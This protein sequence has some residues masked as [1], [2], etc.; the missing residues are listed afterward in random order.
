MQ[1]IEQI[2]IND[3]GSSNPGPGCTFIASDGTFINIYPKIDDHEDLCGYLADNYRVEFEYTDADWFV[4][5]LGWIRLR[6]DP[7]H[8]A[9]V[10]NG[11]R[12]NN[13]QFYSLQEWLEYCEERYQN[14][15]GNIQAYV[16]ICD[17][18][19]YT[20]HTYN[21]MK[22]EFAEDIVRACKRYYTSGHLYAST[23][24]GE[25]DMLTEKEIEDIKSEAIESVY[26]DPDIIDRY[27]DIDEF[28]MYMED[29]DDYSREILYKVY[30]DIDMLWEKCFDEIQRWEDKG[31]VDDKFQATPEQLSNRD[32]YYE[33]VKEVYAD[34][35]EMWME[36]KPPV[37]HDR[38]IKTYTDIAE[39]YCEEYGEPV[40]IEPPN[41][42]ED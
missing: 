19:R 11:T 32:A 37:K 2:A 16:D 21:F 27:S 8:I 18:N 14:N 5:H 12:P 30:L 40:E 17:N 29:P 7:Y 41:Y 4:N 34:L 15:S 13:I 25:L 1:D 31:L 36:D 28:E 42:Y 35:V 9:I 10:L 22:T 39:D 23:D 20:Q 24:I 38:D 26:N 3:F 33:F 6:S